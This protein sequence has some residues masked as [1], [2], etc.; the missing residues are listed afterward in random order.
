MLIVKSECV[1]ESNNKIT[2]EIKALD[3]PSKAGFLCGKP[4]I[5]YLLIEKFRK[6]PES[7]DIASIDKQHKGNFDKILKDLSFK[8]L[9][10]DDVDLIPIIRTE[11]NDEDPLNPVWEPIERKMQTICNGDL[12][13]L[14]KFS[15]FKF[16]AETSDQFYYFNKNNDL[17]YGYMICSLDIII[18]NS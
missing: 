16:E 2:L 5:T 18:D 4:D 3:L 11:D 13:S 14:L 8:A 7:I 1:S 10:G 15:V 17:L 6:T 12:K 9:E